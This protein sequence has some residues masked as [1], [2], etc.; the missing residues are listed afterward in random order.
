[1]KGWNDQKLMGQKTQFSRIQI[2]EAKTNIQDRASGH[3]L[4]L[5]QPFLVPFAPLYEELNGTLDSEERK[6]FAVMKS[7]ERQGE[8]YSMAHEYTANVQNEL[9]EL[10]DDKERKELYKRYASSLLILATKSYDEWTKDVLDWKAEPTGAAEEVSDDDAS[11]NEEE[12]E[13][14]AQ[15]NSL[16]PAIGEIAEIINDISEEVCLPIQLF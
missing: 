5:S 3:E 4:G 12:A 13:T 6:H 15:T 9:K 14:R 10:Q 8:F 16:V 11:D 1:M 2:H 7:V